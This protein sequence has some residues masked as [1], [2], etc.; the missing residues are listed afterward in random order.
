MPQVIVPLDELRWRILIVLAVGLLLIPVQSQPQKSPRI[1]QTVERGKLQ[2]SSNHFFVIRHARILD[3][4][5]VIHA[6]S[7]FIQDGKIQ[8]VGTNL[9]VPPGAAEIDAKGDTLLPG[10]IDSHT[11][12]WVDSTKQAIL[13]GVTTE[14]N[15]AGLP[16]NM[17]KLKHAAA[18][19]DSAD[20][21]SA[22]NVVTPPKGHG[23]EYG[24]AVPTLTR[25]D[26]AQQ[27]VD[28]RIAEGSDYIKI[29][30]EDG[31]VCH[32][33]FARLSSKELA[34]AIAAAHKRGKIAIVHITSQDDAR[35]AI[36]AGADGIAHIFA[37][38]APQADFAK[39]V[40]EHHAFVITTL[41]AIQSSLGTPGADF[42]LTDNR[43]APF[44]SA[45]VQSHLKAHMPSLC[46][47]KIEN[48]FSAIKSLHKA[49]VPI[50]AGTDAP[51]PG[52]SNGVSM[53]EELRLLVR[54]GLSASDAL[55]ASTSFPA[56]VFHLDDR[57]RIAPGLRADLLLVRGDATKD[58]TALSDIIAIWK[59]GIEVERPI[60]RAT[61]SR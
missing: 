23:T 46:S 35:E 47:G 5:R 50:L 55:A 38:S 53:H 19:P 3:G 49:G 30:L 18:G 56:A 29:I 10:L 52:S 44:L 13:F 14:L 54:A 12:D 22:G 34:A 1:F 6:N 37:D 57:G 32:I 36:A 25:A 27:F 4:K 58:I 2:P 15:M 40:A 20:L 28:D 61:P 41:A 26:T 31:H 9:E 24:F 11:H 60:Q 42:L 21:L 43:L 7:V 17:S 33:T 59:A 45:D 39:F 51:S 16:E 48:A 8:S